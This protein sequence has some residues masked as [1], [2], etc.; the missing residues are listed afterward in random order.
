MNS[1]SLQ[2][3]I[4]VDDKGSVKIRQLGKTAQDTGEKGK[5]SFKGWRQQINRLKG[6]TDLSVSSFK[7]MAKVTFAGVITGLGAITLGVG[8]AIG[9]ASDLA[10]TQSKFETVFAGMTKQA[11]AWAEDL[12]QNYLMSEQEARGFLSATQDM[13][14]PMGMMPQAA[15][16]MSHGI[17]QLS[18][19]L[20]SF[21]N[22][23]TEQVI[24]DIQSAL[25]GSYEPML[26]YGA[27]LT[28]DTVAQKAMTMGLVKTK[29]ELTAAHKAQAA[30]QMIVEASSAAVGDMARTSD[31]YANQVKKLHSNVTDLTA[32]MGEHLMPIA[33]DV[34]KQINAGFGNSKGSIDDLATTISIKLLQ[35]LGSA[36]E[37]MRFFHNGWLGIK[38][39]GT[40]AIDA[41]AQSLDFLFTGLRQLLLP[42]DMAMDGLVQLG[43]ID[44]NPFDGIEAALGTFATSSR[45]VTK[46][47]MADIADTNATYDAIGKK[48]DE[49]GEQ[50]KTA[51]SQQQKMGNAAEDA[52]GKVDNL[53]VAADKTGKRIVAAA[54]ART[55]EQLALEEDLTKKINALTLSRFDCERQELEKNIAAMRAK[56]NGDK[57]L[58][59]DIAKYHDLTLTKIGDAE[60]KAREDSLAA[61]RDKLQQLLGMQD[62]LTT[63]HADNLAARQEAARAAL[64]EEMVRIEEAKNAYLQSLRD[65][66]VSDEA[67]A[68]E[69]Q[70]LD[71]E[72]A[73][74]QQKKLKEI[75]EATQATTINM[76]QFFGEMA[77]TIKKT[78][79]Q[80]LGKALIDEFGGIESGWGRVW[81]A[82]LAKMGDVLAEMAVNFAVSEVANLFDWDLMKFHTGLWDL[83]DDEM[84]AILQQGEMVIPRGPA[85]V[86]RDTLGS[87][88]NGHDF[89]TIATQ[90]KEYNDIGNYDDRWSQM[91]G[92]HVLRRTPSMLVGMLHGQ[93]PLAAIAGLLSPASIMSFA[94]H[95]IKEYVYDA[96]V[97]TNNPAT[98]IGEI[99]GMIG[100]VMGLAANPV[101]AGIGLIAGG[102]LGDRLGDALD[103]RPRETL[104]DEMEDLGIGKDTQENAVEYADYVESINQQIRQHQIND[105]QQWGIVDIPP[106]IKTAQEMAEEAALKWAIE[107]EQYKQ[108]KESKPSISGGSGE[109][110]SDR[111]PV[112]EGNVIIMPMREPSDNDNGVTYND[113]GT[114]TITATHHKKPHGGDHDKDSGSSSSGGDSRDTGSSDFDNDPAFA[115]G[116]VVSRLKVPNGEDG[117][118]F[119]RL[120]EGV[121]DKDT[122]KILS[123]EIRAGRFGRGGNNA[124]STELL[125]ELK[126]IYQALYTIARNTNDSA[127]TLQKI[128]MMGLRLEK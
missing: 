99:I 9:A 27:V 36:I 97:V 103:L 59:D 107:Q 80:E 84:P 58:L 20:G 17:A 39:A 32:A 18:A 105:Y 94:T 48:I 55:K 6:D 102:Y 126:N 74:Y 100:A 115:G 125:Q 75:E 31:G 69:R 92:H 61:N 13:L 37:I 12:R 85:Q 114:V 5:K 40:V 47:V 109:S 16:E 7:T 96:A 89:E 8:K 119:L 71:T 95:V 91:W 10:E 41:I 83:A 110:W 33:A 28:A 118:A 81:D 98:K 24:G 90:I 34:L 78:A 120:G 68:A 52:A 19:D 72:I 29:E 121:I 106:M 2:I 63:A 124:L 1:S 88:N 86:I 14:V 46:Q 113:D 45:N 127:E 112:K 54:S 101:V 66:G 50:I 21:N 23:P 64:E 77:D 65:K 43:T 30:Y 60:S 56:A 93:N 82:M 38:L 87:G 57:A 108:E 53:G 22:L 25:V 67:Y 42:L 73:D 62:D 15:G 3:S 104:R 117:F 122:T 76:Q 111:H 116:G 11:N 35:A 123:D 44:V 49:Y 4:E 128:D 51:A 26:K 79:G 70:R